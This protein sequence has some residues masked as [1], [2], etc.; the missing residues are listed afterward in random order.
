MNRMAPKRKKSWLRHGV[1]G[2]VLGALAFV[3]AVFVT[4][5]AK[6]AMQR[7]NLTAAVFVL[8][9]LVGVG[10]VGDLVGV[11]A[12]A[13]TEPGLHAMAARR[14]P[15]ARGALALKRRADR[16]TSIASDIVGDI[17]GTISGAAAAVVGARLWPGDALPLVIGS[18]VA[19]TVGGRAFM[20]GVALENANQIL[21]AVGYVGYWL[22]RL[23]GRRGRRWS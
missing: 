15:G 5:P 2:L 6:A 17:A 11:A 1:R 20:K 7:L 18:V 13:A 22:G 12:A 23:L 8:L 3:I 9:A 10:V 16:V 4:L 21:Y 14:L 19:L